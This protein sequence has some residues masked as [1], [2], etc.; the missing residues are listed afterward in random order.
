MW[1]QTISITS[2][3]LV[4]ELIFVNKI[5][6]LVSCLYLISSYLRLYFRIRSGTGNMSKTQHS[7]TKEQNT[8]Q[9]HQ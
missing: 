1:L 5:F 9:G 6:Q 4:T 3:I 2:N 8:A 7:P